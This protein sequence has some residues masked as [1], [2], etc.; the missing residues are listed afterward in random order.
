MKAFKFLVVLTGFI[1]LANVPTIFACHGGKHSTGEMVSGKYLNTPKRDNGFMMSVDLTLSMR[2]STAG[3]FLVW[4]EMTGTTTDC[5][6]QLANIHMYFH[7]NYEQIAEQSAQGE[8]HHLEALA[9]QVGCNAQQ[10][11]LLEKALQQNYQNV[12]DEDDINH[13]ISE[14]YTVVNSDEQLAACWPKS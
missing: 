4:L 5:D 12:F 7:K 14:F 6:F 10:T 9:S 8:G 13:A 1:L 3:F 2:L 11:V